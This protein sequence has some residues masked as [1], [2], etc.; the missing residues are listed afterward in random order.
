LLNFRTRLQDSNLESEMRN[1]LSK[2]QRQTGVHAVIE[3]IGSGAPVA[4]E[5]QLQVLFILQEALSNVRKH[6]QA[7]EVKVRV[8]N[9][10]DF[11]LII[12]DD[13]QGFTMESAEQKGDA[14]VGLHIMRER[15]ERLSAQFEI[16]SVPGQGTTISL[17]LLRQERLVA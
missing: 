4:P 11:K 2:F 6:A 10:R 15:A 17:H 14:H 8:E 5:Q 13:G 7:S 9:E 3:F 12:T 1:V 16:C